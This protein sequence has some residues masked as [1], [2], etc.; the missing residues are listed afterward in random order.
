MQK[1]KRKIVMIQEFT[2]TAVF[3]GKHYAYFGIHPKTAFL[4]GDKPEDI[5]TITIKISDNQTPVP[6]NSEKDSSK[7]DYW[8]YYD[9]ESRKFTHIYPAYFL[10]NM[11][12]P[13]GIKAEEDRN[14]G[15]AYRLEIIN[16]KP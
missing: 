5:E 11:C 6:P 8:G 7:P 14:F 13:Y 16:T 4:Y 3:N 15:K 1:N 12:F 10:L 2:T 9:N